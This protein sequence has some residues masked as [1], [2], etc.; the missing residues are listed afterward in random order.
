MKGTKATKVLL[1]IGIVFLIIGIL[2]MFFGSSDVSRI[3]IFISV[4]LN[5]VGLAIK[6]NKKSK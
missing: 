6:R 2:F 3:M 1:I 4:I 5:T